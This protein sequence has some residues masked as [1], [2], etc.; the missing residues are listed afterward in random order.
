MGRNGGPGQALG[1][2][3]VTTPDL[4]IVLRGDQVGLEHDPIVDHPGQPADYIHTDGTVWTWQQRWRMSGNADQR[5]R[6]RLY[7][8]VTPGDD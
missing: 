5:V 7:D 1:S 6:L 8:L 4:R 2:L 3:I